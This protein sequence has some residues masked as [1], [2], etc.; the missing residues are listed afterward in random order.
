MLHGAPSDPQ[1]QR[2]T[3]KAPLFSLLPFLPTRCSWLE[4]CD[5]V[6]PSLSTRTEI[7]HRARTFVLFYLCTSMLLPSN[8]ESTLNSFED[9]E[10]VFLWVLAP[11]TPRA[12]LVLHEELQFG[13]QSP[14]DII[15]A[16]SAC[17][18]HMAELQHIWSTAGSC[19]GGFCL[20]L[21]L[22]LISP[23]LPFV[24]APPSW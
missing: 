8:G 15:P 23:R 3:L 20:G 11:R 16:C 19:Q 14:L 21:Q 4:E 18:L 13:N 6:L 1:S 5:G 24:Q 10:N 2:L 12:R 7:A 17:W 9:M 22:R